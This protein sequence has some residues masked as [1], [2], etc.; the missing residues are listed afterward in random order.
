[1]NT[2]DAKCL[3]YNYAAT[4]FELEK[5]NLKHFSFQKKNKFINL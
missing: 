4:T 2:R 3:T 1:M 5:K